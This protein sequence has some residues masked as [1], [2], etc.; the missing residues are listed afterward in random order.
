MPDDTALSAGRMRLQL[1]YDPQVQRFHAQY[2]P[3][4]AAAVIAG[5]KAPAGSAIEG[6]DFVSTWRGPDGTMLTGISLSHTGGEHP[7][8]MANGGSTAY[9]NGM[10]PLGDW[11]ATAYS[12]SEN[13]PEHINIDIYWRS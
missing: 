1:V 10:S 2:D 7:A 5:D 8:G 13:V 6:V 11:E 4:D 3:K 9:F 12:Y